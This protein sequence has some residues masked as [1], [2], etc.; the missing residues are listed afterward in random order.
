MSPG[1][2]AVVLPRA[3]L[4]SFGVEDCGAASLELVLATWGLEASRETLDA[5]LPKAA[6]GGVL[7]LDLV[8]EARA[9]GFSARLLEGNQETV[10]DS[11]ERGIPPI[12]VLQVIDSLGRRNDYFHFVVADGLDRERKLVSLQFGDGTRRWT[13]FA[14]I[15]QPWGGAGH[16]MILIEPKKDPGSTE[17]SNELRYAVALEARGEWAGARSIYRRL[18]EQSDTSPLLWTNLGNLEMS[19]ERLVEAEQAYRRALELE[20]GYRDALNNLAWLLATFGDAL[21]EALELARRAL[22]ADGPDPHFVLDTLARVHL[23]R[24]DCESAR[25]AIERALALAP[26]STG[27]G[28]LQE[29]AKRIEAEC[30]DRRE[31]EEDRAGRTY[32]SI[33]G[34]APNPGP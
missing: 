33:E 32:G 2:T 12:L 14:K 4:S 28:A 5:R 30:A 3:P 6:N 10:F 17:D 9:R 31:T 34:Y 11:L 24:G 1:P 18:I 20:P 19:A 25:S 29:E 27:L 7:T 15:E 21:D 22:E 16:G 8:L 26:P 23:Q 13:T